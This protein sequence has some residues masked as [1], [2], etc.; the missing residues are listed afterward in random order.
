M[1]TASLFALSGTASAQSG[2]PSGDTTSGAYVGAETATRTPPLSPQVLGATASNP[3]SGSAAT[4]VVRANSLA[5]TG[6]DVA[7]LSLMGGI[8]LV[9][10]VGFM[11]ARRK[12]VKLA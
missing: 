3:A 10:G 4:P 11:V 7:V 5:F 1:V 2:T 6:G 9:A 8:A 12:T